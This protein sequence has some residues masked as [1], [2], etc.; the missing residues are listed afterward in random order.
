MTL[1]RRSSVVRSPK[2]MR[3]TRTTR[4]SVGRSPKRVSAP[5]RMSGSRKGNAYMQ[6]AGKYRKMYPMPGVPVPEQGRRIGAAYRRAKA[7]GRMSP[8]PVRQPA[9]MPVLR[10]MSP[11]KSRHSPSRK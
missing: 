11:Q 5:R 7:S 4:M 10:R 1:M 9:S 8:S 3:M 6:F 2:R